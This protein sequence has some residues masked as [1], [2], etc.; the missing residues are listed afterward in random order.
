MNSPL[1]L[2]LKIAS[3]YLLLIVLLGVIVFVVRHGKQQAISLNAAERIV[4][5][6]RLTV[7]RTFEQLLSLSFSDDLLLSG[8]TAALAAYRSKRLARSYSE[9]RFARMK[10][11]PVFISLG[12]FYIFS[13]LPLHWG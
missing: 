11:V 7:N 6:K 10:G 4:Q 5:A 9:D 1:P 3:G 2:R 12:Q 8:D 13:P